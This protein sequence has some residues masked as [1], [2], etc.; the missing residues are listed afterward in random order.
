MTCHQMWQQACYWQLASHTFQSTKV[1]LHEKTDRLTIA[2]IFTISPAIWSIIELTVSYV[3]QPL[4]FRYR[5]VINWFWTRLIPILLQPGT[6]LGRNRNQYDRPWLIS[7]MYRLLDI[8]AD[9]EIFTTVQ[10]SQTCRGPVRGGG[11]SQNPQMNCNPVPVIPNSDIGC[12]IK[13]LISHVVPITSQ[14]L[15]WP[16]GPNR[17]L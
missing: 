17:A 8:D 11:W 16:I 12:N 9:S 3:Q 1:S 14:T 6:I 10:I 5:V 2:T 15:N 13:I 7:E 4:Y